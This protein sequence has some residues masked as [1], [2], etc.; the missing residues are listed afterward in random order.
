[1]ISNWPAY[2][3]F[4][5]Q[6]YRN[7]DFCIFF[8]WS[9]GVN[10]RAVWTKLQHTL[11]NRCFIWRYCCFVQFEWHLLGKQYPRLWSHRSIRYTICSTPQTTFK[12]CSLE[13]AKSGLWRR[14][15]RI[16]YSEY[17]IQYTSMWSRPNG[18]IQTCWCIQASHSYFII[19]LK[20]Q[21]TH[22]KS[23]YRNYAHT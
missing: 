9:M 5:G 17:R 14:A 19:W 4:I 12:W 6:N 16:A 10:F 18:S 15:N 20:S 23:L 1:M 11:M 21:M 2:S 13:G 7:S 22:F 8:A 3:R